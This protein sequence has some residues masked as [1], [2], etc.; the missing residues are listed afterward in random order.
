[1]PDA[2]TYF[3]PFRRFKE[4]DKTVCGIDLGASSTGVTILHKDKVL[5][6][7]TFK[8]KT[9]NGYHRCAEMSDRIM[10]YINSF[11]PSLVVLEDYIQGASRNLI[12]ENVT[13]GE[14]GGTVR[15]K[16]YLAKYNFILVHPSKMHSFLGTKITDE[17]RRKGYIESEFGVK[18]KSVHESDAFIHAMIGLMALSL[19][20]KK[21]FDVS[22]KRYQLLVSNVRA[23]NSKKPLGVLRRPELV[24]A[25]KEG[26]VTV[27]EEDRFF[28]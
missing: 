4:I 6:H 18:F 13:I 17:K 19:F 1:M 3:V 15:T 24:Y 20:S 14:F 2:E 28:Y 9:R 12:F 5:G 25:F 16:L 7:E 21:R 10:E 11:S 23:K 26:D 27:L 22:D 8:P